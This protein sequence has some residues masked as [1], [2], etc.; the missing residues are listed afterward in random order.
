MLISAP[1][2]SSEVILGKTIPYVI[3]GMC[4]VPLILGFAMI[5]FGVPMRGSL[6]VLLIASLAFVCTTVAVGTLISTLAK[7]QSQSTMGGFIFIFPAI[8]LSS[9]MFP[10]ENMPTLMKWI[11]YFDPLFHFLS[12]LRNIMLKGGEA[13]FVIF[14]VS[15]LLV[16][17]LV[18]IFI[19]FR[20][21]HTT[22]S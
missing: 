14:H 17:A 11:A 22:L 7:N 6:L 15:V 12:L 2:R 3:L 21:F 16:M 8:L 18:S 5:V 19:S 10:V 20:R 4:N 13:N 1:L 9:L